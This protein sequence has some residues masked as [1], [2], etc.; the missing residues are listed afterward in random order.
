ML[1]KKLAPVILVVAI[2]VGCGTTK[3]TAIDQ[4]YLA[5]ES[6]KTVQIL[7]EQYVSQPTASNEVKFRL[8]QL[9]REMIVALS[10]MKAAAANGTASDVEFYSMLMAN[11]LVQLRTVLEEEGVL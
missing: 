10:N 11:I 9:D 4:T 7:I 6:Y 5:A 3:P 1:R 8:K 2:T